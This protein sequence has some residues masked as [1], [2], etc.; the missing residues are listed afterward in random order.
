M[1]Q[2]FSNRMGILKFHMDDMKSRESFFK[3]IITYSSK[4]R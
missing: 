1:T 3:M 4:D 2:Q